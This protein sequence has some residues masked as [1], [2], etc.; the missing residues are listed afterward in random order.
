[1]SYNQEDRTAGRRLGVQRT[2]FTL[3]VKDGQL[4]YPV[5][6]PDKTAPSATHPADRCRCGRSR[7]RRQRGAASCNPQ[8]ESQQRKVASEAEGFWIPGGK[9]TGGVVGVL[10][11]RSTVW[12]IADGW[13]TKCGK[14]QR[15]SKTS[16]SLG[17]RIWGRHKD[18]Q[19]QRQACPRVCST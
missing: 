10:C 7:R 15:R 14:V 12:A 2:R 8:G 9:L 18:A 5:C 17:P 3:R 19:R 11:S 6:L 1:M 13:T 16:P 4:R